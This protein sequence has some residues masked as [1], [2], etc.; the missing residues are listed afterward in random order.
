LTYYSSICALLIKRLSERQ[1]NVRLDI[2][3][4][5]S[6]LLNETKKIRS[7]I[8]QSPSFKRRKASNSTKVPALTANILAELETL[9]PD[10]VKALAAQLAGKSELSMIA[11]YNL[12]KEMS[13]IVPDSL[14]SLMSL[15]FVTNQDDSVSSTTLVSYRH[16]ERKHKS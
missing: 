9:T 13:Q 2:F 8:V 16:E 4:A 3:G 14:S 7:K 12:L 10:M 1:E 5:L 11:A 6:T 15:V